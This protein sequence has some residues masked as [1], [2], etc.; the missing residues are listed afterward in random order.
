MGNLSK[1]EAKLQ[2]ESVLHN[3]LNKIIGNGLK[4]LG[5]MLISSTNSN[6][7]LT[8]YV[9]SLEE[10]KIYVGTTDRCLRDRICEHFSD[11]GSEWTKVYKP[12]KV[13]EIIE[14]ADKFDEDKY[15]KIYMNKYGIDNV[16]GGSYCMIELSEEQKKLLK[17]E[18]KTANN[19]CF[20]CGKIGHYA[21]HCPN[22]SNSHTEDQIKQQSKSSHKF[23]QN[24][25]Y[26]CGRTTH[27]AKDCYAKNDINGKYLGNK[28]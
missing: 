16:R 1:P 4:N 6:K 11:N 20:Y 13:V 17:T 22:K 19:E 14:N 18:F 2:Q 23:P 8:L 27:W 25:C 24:S 12:I 9:L 5:D 26:R 15:T 28:K 21:N 10:D 7:T 3:E